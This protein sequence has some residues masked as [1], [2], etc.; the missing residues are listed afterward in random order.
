LL[1]SVVLYGIAA[2]AIPAIMTAAVGDYLGIARAAGAFSLITF[3]FA[4]GQ[5]VGPALAGII[6]EASGSFAP[7]FL[8]TAALT[9][10][11]ALLALKLPRPS[12]S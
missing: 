2:W 5:T 10:V 4:G 12:G 1:A 8:L 7:A 9:G 6:A 3:F 11:A